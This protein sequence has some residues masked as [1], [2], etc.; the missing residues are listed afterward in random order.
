MKCRE[1]DPA[2]GPAGLPRE[3]VKNENQGLGKCCKCSDTV[4]LFKLLKKEVI[5]MSS[6]ITNESFQP[7]CVGLNKEQ[8]L[9]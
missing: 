4:P 8:P 1:V 2:T 6:E 5:Q 9:F 7:G 3:R